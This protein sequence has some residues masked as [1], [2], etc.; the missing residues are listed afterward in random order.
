MSLPGLRSMARML[1]GTTSRLSA[2]LRNDKSNGLTIFVFHD[3]TDAP[4]AFAID[5]DQYIEPSRFE[6]QVRWI[7][8][9]FRVT[10]VHDL[11][12]GDDRRLRGAA[13]ITFD[14]GWEGAF[15]NGLPIL[16]GH[17]LSG[18]H[19]LKACPLIEPYPAIPAFAGYLSRYSP[20]FAQDRALRPP[21]HLTPSPQLLNDLVDSYGDGWIGEA[22]KYQGRLVP[23]ESLMEFSTAQDVSVGSHLYEHWNSCALS[24]SEFQPDYRR[25]VASLEEKR[26]FV[27]MGAFPNGQSSRRLPTPSLRNG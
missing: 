22:L 4:S 26:N 14:D 11:L 6:R 17:G 13:L 10:S 24:E 19:F 20:A 1:A 15:Q 3:L 2:S 7:R 27:P 8:A 16:R 18:T 23:H 12:T 5:Y 25:I 21:H 9:K